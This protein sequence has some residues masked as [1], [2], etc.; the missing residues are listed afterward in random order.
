[1]IRF[2][3][4]KNHYNKIKT[5]KMNSFYANQ[6][7]INE[8]PSNITHLYFDDSFD[9]PLSIGIIPHTVTHLT[10]GKNF[11][12]PIPIGVIPNSV[13]HLTFGRDFNQPLTIHMIPNSVTHLTFDTCFNQPL[14]ENVIPSSVT[15]LTFGMCFNQKLNPGNIPNSVKHLTF[16]FCYN[17]SI[18]ENV[19]P[20]SVTHVTFGD[21]YMRPYV[22][23]DS[24]IY[25]NNTF[26]FKSEMNIKNKK[27]VEN[28]E[29]CNICLESKSTLITTC[30]HQ[31]CNTCFENLYK[32]NNLC[33]YCRKE[34]YYHDL[35]LIQ[36][37]IK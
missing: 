30:N 12:K 25:L 32:N 17:Q 8:I 13:T 10:F 21:F 31:Y 29:N 22:L 35:F 2:N 20:N 23:P 27:I 26:I 33:A 7:N 5:I 18:D 1:M 14:N 37:E 3:Y 9:Q 6:N 11:N 36:N 28:I 16:G 34:L 15:H 4:K 24:V 19:I